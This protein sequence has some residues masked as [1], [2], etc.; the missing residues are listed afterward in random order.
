MNKTRSPEQVWCT[1]T[2][3]KQKEGWTRKGWWWVR[4]R[5]FKPTRTYYI[6]M[7]DGHKNT[8][9]YDLN[10]F[11]GGEHHNELWTVAEL[12]YGRENGDCASWI[13]DYT[14][15]EDT[16]TGSDSGR[17]ARIWRHV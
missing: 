15:T 2:N 3:H 16:V 12:L 10:L 1:C 11:Q 17:V 6:Q 9:R 8:P 14:W 4:P 7:V 13:T 5:C